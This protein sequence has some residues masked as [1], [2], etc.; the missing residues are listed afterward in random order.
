[1]ADKRRVYIVRDVSSC[2]ECDYMHHAEADESDHAK[3]YCTHPSVAGRAEIDDT[4]IIPGWCRLE[5]VPKPGLKCPECGGDGETFSGY[6]GHPETSDG[7]PIMHTCT[8]CNG[9]G[10]VDETT[11]MKYKNARSMDPY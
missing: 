10:E 3:Q 11:H 8:T 5:K 7:G 6:Y 1:M 4:S 2:G 9:S